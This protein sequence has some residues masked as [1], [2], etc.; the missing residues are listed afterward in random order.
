M[1]HS[2]LTTTCIDVKE[3]NI[4]YGPSHAVE[5]ISFEVAKGERFV[6]MGR[7]GC[8]KSTL[9]K[10]IGG[11]VPITSGSI[12]VNG[13]SV[14]KPSPSRIMVWQDL[15]QLLP[16]KNVESNVAWPLL[17]AK[18][19]KK[20]AFERARNWIDRVGLSKAAKN[21]PHQL[22]GGMSQRVALAR[23]FA[24][25]PEVLLMDEPFSALDALIREKLQDV[26]IALQEQ[27]GTT[28]VF[29]SHDC[30]EGARVG[31]RILVLSPHPGRVKS[32]I[33]AENKS[34]AELEEHLRGLI[35]EEDD[36][37]DQLQEDT[38][39]SAHA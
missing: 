30:A 28:V 4:D 10:A 26:V 12:K 5:D 19:P 29:V 23:A 17:L 22:S 27:E 14:S 36:H 21:Y 33:K 11:F 20:E 18:I 6:L 39:R 3:V 7:S 1:A 32:I 34:P 2:A 13:H 25:N 9:L 37:N 16:W 35:H 15:A 8:G 31:N 24:L 38:R